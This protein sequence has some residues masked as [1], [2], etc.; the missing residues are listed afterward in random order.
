M[1]A[2]IEK[3]KVHRGSCQEVWPALEKPDISWRLLSCVAR[4]KDAANGKRVPAI[5]AN[6]DVFTFWIA[7]GD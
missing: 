3:L 5:A 4:M 6:R 1:Y 7:L 2:V